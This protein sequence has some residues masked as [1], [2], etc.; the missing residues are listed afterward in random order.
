MTSGRVDAF[1][2]E[3]N[4]P[5]TDLAREQYAK[6]RARGESIKVASSSAGVSGA[7]GT[8]FEKHPAMLKRVSELRQGAETYIGVS[9]AWCIQQVQQIIEEAREHEQYK[10]A[11]EGVVFV[12]KVIS[13]DKSVAPQ[14]ARALSPD[15]TPRQLKKMLDATFPSQKA[16]PAYVAPAVPVEADEDEGEAAE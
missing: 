13:G 12:H 8:S 5:F 3:P 15:V 16:L 7:T 6:A 11:L 9:T 10:T 1:H 4:G 2:R 14:M